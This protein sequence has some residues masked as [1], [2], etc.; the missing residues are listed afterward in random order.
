MPRPDYREMMDLLF[1]L[2]GILHIQVFKQ[3]AAGDELGRPDFGLLALLSRV[4]SASQSEA[5]DR[6]RMSRPQM[7]VV[8]DRLVEKG[9]ALRERDELDRRITRVSATAEGIKAMDEAVAATQARIEE[10]LAPLGARELEAA[11][12]ALRQ[13]V[14][15]LR[16]GEKGKEP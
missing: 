14:A 13:L 15:A 2:H 9:M 1:T 16:K 3:G 5:A 6:L 8:V 7:S 11:V 4:G 10:L 12:A